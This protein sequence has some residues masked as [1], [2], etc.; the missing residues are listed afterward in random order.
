[1][2]NVRNAN[3]EVVWCDDSEAIGSGH[4][5]LVRHS[6]G[7]CIQPIS[8]RAPMSWTRSPWTLAWPRQNI[9]IMLFV[10]IMKISPVNEIWSGE[11]KRSLSDDKTSAEF[12]NW[13]IQIHS[14]QRVDFIMSGWYNGLQPEDDTSSS[15]FSGRLT[16]YTEH[17]YTAQELQT[18]VRED[19]IIAKKA[20]IHANQ[21]TCP[22]RQHPNCT[23][24]YGL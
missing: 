7:T 23:S 17:Q 13:I 1:M 22:L 19:L 6:T 14:G 20:S 9:I 12:T 11:I 8:G 16:H 4:E 24:Y 15:P 10:I 5:A 3:V 2:R 18:K 21:T